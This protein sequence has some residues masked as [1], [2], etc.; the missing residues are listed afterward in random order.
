[1]NVTDRPRRPPLSPLEGWIFDG[2]QVL[3]F[4]PINDDHWSQ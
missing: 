1:M 3:N 2:R 4:K